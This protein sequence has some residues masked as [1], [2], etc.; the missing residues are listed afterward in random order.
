MRYHILLLGAMLT[1]A[2]IVP[3][4]AMGA[5]DDC[6]PPSEQP[7]EDPGYVENDP[8]P[9]NDDTGDG[10]TGGSGETT[11]ED[12][13]TFGSLGGMSGGQLTLAALVVVG[14]IVGVVYLLMVGRMDG[15]EIEYEE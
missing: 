2:L 10:G 13:G 3:M 9:A 12:D 4:S 11:S 8:P 6:P 7:F 1:L 14:V 15:D 5:G